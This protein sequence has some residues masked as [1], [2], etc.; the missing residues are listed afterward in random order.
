MN[1]AFAIM[2]ICATSIFAQGRGTGARSRAAGID[3]AS[4]Q[5]VQGTV[6]A[7]YLAYG[8]Q[9]PSIVVAGK[10][11]KVAPL[12]FFVD[13]D[14][15]IRV[16]DNLVVAAASS[17]NQGDSYL[18]ALQITNNTTQMQIDLRGRI[19]GSA[20]VSKGRRETVQTAG[21]S[22]VHHLDDHGGRSD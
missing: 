13:H 3:L 17:T 12:W 1:R 5:T 9:Y 8:V 10:N 22:T 18:Y 2:V 21:P 4:F 19:R 6:S 14:F 11:I 15:E 16:G 7:V 20:L